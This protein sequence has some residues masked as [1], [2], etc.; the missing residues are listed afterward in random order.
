MLIWLI[1]ALAVMALTAT[2]GAG[3]FWKSRKSSGPA[4]ITHTIA[5]GVFEHN[6][7]ERGEVES[8]S[9][10]D[11]RCQVKARNGAGTTIIEVVPEGTLVQAGD[12]VVKLDATALEQER[13][14]Q[15][16]ACNTKQA[17]MIEAQNQFEAAKIAMQEYTEGTYHQEEQTIKSEILIAEENLRKSQEYLAYSERLAARGYVTAQQLEGDAFAV[18]KAK[19]ELDTAETKLRVLREYTKSKTLRQL[20]SD[21]K[22]AEARWKSEQSS[23]ELELNKLQDLEQQIVLCEIKAPQTG[24]VLYANERSFRGG[25]SDF[26][27]EPGALVRENQAIL[28]LPDAT[29]MQVKAKINEAR[30]TLIQPKMTASV[31]LDALGDATFPGRVTRVNEY[32]E[33]SSWFSSQVKEY[34][35]YIR[36]LD[37]PQRIR[38]GLTAEVTIHVERVE[39]AIIVPVQAIAERKRRYFCVAQ[40][41]DAWEARPVQV[42]ATNDKYVMLASGV[43]PGEVVAMNPKDL[44]ETLTIA[45]AP[46]EGLSAPPASAADSNPRRSDQGPRAA[47]AGPSNRSMSHR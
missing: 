6:V 28:R 2:V 40:V 38:P 22:S 45:E 4:V 18:E 36:I 20:E 21:I 43:E 32:P 41:G 14:V 29:K 24:Q 9:N 19:T 12:V 13:V 23:Y 3:F 27:V 5:R 31:R 7:V 26:V 34:A 35:T 15:Q 37:S 17:A 46:A 10:I 44:L 1:L 42:V 33:P 47:V 8:A 30:V 39:D 11:V 16:I 25:G